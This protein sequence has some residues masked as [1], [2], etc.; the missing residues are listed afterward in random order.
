VH[1]IASAVATLRGLRS[2]GSDEEDRKGGASGGGGG[3]KFVADNTK[4][5]VSASVPVSST[6]ARDDVPVMTPRACP[7]SRPVSVDG[8][9]S[10]A[11]SGAVQRPR[12][13]ATQAASNIRFMEGCWRGAI[14]PRPNLGS[15]FARTHA[16]QRASS[17]HGAGGTTQTA[18]WTAK[19]RARV[20]E[21]HFIPHVL[22]RA[23]RGADRRKANMA[24]AARPRP[25]TMSSIR[26]YGVIRSTLRNPERC[27]RACERSPRGLAFP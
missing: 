20:F 13:S 16:R 21:L 7:S 10:R 27:F 2:D 12:N 24:L 3:L 6:A 18:Q 5:P 9:R 25:T 17:S 14:C 11:A 22:A 26:C 8:V 19:G 15:P 23:G 4:A 1:L